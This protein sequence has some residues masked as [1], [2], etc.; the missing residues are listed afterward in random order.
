MNVYTGLHDRLIGSF[1]KGGEHG[2]PAQV[3]RPGVSPNTIS[4]VHCLSVRDSPTEDDLH[5]KRGPL[6]CLAS[7]GTHGINQ[8]A[9]APAAHC[10][11]L[12]LQLCSSLHGCS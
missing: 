2:F 11:R 12:H 9:T 6:D 7:L 3:H 1:Q 4:A 8:R 10:A 5:G